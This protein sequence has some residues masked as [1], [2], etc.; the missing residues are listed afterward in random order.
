M[1][2]ALK[3][4]TLQKDLQL[5]CNIVITMSLNHP[6][7]RPKR[8]PHLPQAPF[9]AKKLVLLPISQIMKVFYS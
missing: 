6:T 3:L 4:C 2:R 5:D 9:Y 1:L 7:I 8:P